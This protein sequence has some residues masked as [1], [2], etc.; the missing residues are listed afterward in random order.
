MNTHSF[1]RVNQH[2]LSERLQVRALCVMADDFACRLL[3]AI[4]FQ[5]SSSMQFYLHLTKVTGLW[6]CFKF[7]FL[8]FDCR[9]SHKNELQ[10]N[11]DFLPLFFT[12]DFS[13]MLNSSMLALR[14][15]LGSRN[16]SFNRYKKTLLNRNYRYISKFF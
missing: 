13:S 11:R 10:K 4:A 8:T 2:Y 12:V 15:V 6:Y 9:S 5:H 14:K 16:L 3:L 7:F 1:H